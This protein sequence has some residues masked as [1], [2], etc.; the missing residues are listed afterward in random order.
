ME[1]EGQRFL[2][3]AHFLDHI[4]E[5]VAAGAVGLQLD[6]EID[7]VGRKGAG[8]EAVHPHHGFADGAFAEGKGVVGGIAHYGNK[9]VVVA[10][11]AKQQ[12]AVGGGQ[13]FVGKCLHGVFLSGIKK[14]A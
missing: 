6:I 5:M 2:F 13:G 9:A 3:G 10:L 14:A 7:F 1:L 12:H 4:V 8:L 11:G